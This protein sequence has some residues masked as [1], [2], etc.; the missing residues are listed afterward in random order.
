MIDEDVLFWEIARILT[1][2]PREALPELAGRLAR[3]EAI[4]RMRLAGMEHAIPPLG[5]RPSAR[6]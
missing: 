5:P 2:C 3:C 4:I 6:T 1:E